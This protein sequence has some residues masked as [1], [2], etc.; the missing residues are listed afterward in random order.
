MKVIAFYT[1]TLNF[2][3]TCVAIVDYATYNEKLLLNKSIIITNQCNK[4]DDI[5][6]EWITKLFNV[7]YIEHVNTNTLDDVLISNN[8]DVLYC[9]KYG[10]ND[11]IY[12]NKVKTIIHCVFNMSEPH[13]DVYIGVS[14]SLCKKFN[15]KEYLGHIVKR[16][17]TDTKKNLRTQ[18]NIPL[19]AL[20]IGRH[21]GIDT[22][23]VEFAK[24]FISKI[25]RNNNNIYFLFINAPIWDVHPQLIYLQP[26]TSIEFKNKFIKTCDAMIVP[27]S[28]GHSF[29]LSISE[30][31]MFKKPI[32]CYLNRR[33]RNVYW[34]DNHI[35]ELGNEGLYFSNELE[36]SLIINNFNMFKNIIPYKAYRK[37]T[38]ERVMSLFNRYL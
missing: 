22:F 18:L 25:I 19:D 38:P 28:L 3:G 35:N 23:N 34:N 5:A 17:N 30:F 7:I 14:K 1:P 26:T 33:N 36:L 4:H 12:S 29:G 32:I 11:G 24:Q 8:C 13:G 27:E 9:I 21:G 6:V 20:V 16:V 2:R 37:Y 10:K 31:C 15:S